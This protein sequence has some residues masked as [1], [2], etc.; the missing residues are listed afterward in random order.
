MCFSYV[1]KSSF[2]WNRISVLSNYINNQILIEK[3]KIRC[4]SKYIYFQEKYHRQW[5]LI[6]SY[7]FRYLSSG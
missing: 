5:S 4:K 6:I 2:G 1:F 7:Y 3:I